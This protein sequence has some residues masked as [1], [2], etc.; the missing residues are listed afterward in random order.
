[1]EHLK[2]ED[3]NASIFISGFSRFKLSSRRGSD[4]ES[5][6][7]FREISCSEGEES[8]IDFRQQCYKTFYG[9]NLRVDAIS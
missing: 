2:G 3:P 7:D 9:C 6:R 1:V 5:L 8:Q 4:L